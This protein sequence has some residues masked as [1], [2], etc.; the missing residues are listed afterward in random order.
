MS[1]KAG[2]HC[3][4]GGIAIND[5]FRDETV[6]SGGSAVAQADHAEWTLCFTVIQA[7]S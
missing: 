1:Y 4:F 3:R 6:F 7:R 2:A 5:V